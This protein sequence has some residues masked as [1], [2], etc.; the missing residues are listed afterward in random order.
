[1]TVGPGRLSANC[2]GDVGVKGNLIF[3]FEIEHEFYFVFIFDI[4]N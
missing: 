3:E 1:M 4:E 2:W